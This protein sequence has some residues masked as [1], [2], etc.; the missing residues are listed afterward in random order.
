VKNEKGI[1]IK[2]NTCIK[3]KSMGASGFPDLTSACLFS[4]CVK[5]ESANSLKQGLN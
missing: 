1:A 4:R 3:Q 2:E 5:F